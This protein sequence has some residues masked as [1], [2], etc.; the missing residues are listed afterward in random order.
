MPEPVALVIRGGV[1]TC[2]DARAAG[3]Q[4]QVGQI[5]VVRIARRQIDKFWVHAVLIPIVFDHLGIYLTL[6]SDGA[7]LVVVEDIALDDISDRALVAPIGKVD[8]SLEAGVGLLVAVMIERVPVDAII[9]RMILTGCAG[10]NLEPSTVV[11]DRT[12]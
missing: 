4:V 9:V 10:D 11:N 1:R 8:A 7:V 2:V 6:V 12:G 5:R 3:L